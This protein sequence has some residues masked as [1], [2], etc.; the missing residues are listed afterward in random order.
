MS[1]VSKNK[2]KNKTPRGRLNEHAGT[3]THAYILT[4]SALP[5]QPCSHYAHLTAINSD[6]ETQAQKQTDRDLQL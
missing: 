4:R 5:G 6:A 2:L 1:T 3:R